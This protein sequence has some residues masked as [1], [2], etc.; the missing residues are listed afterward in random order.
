MTVTISALSGSNRTF[1]FTKT[2]PSQKLIDTADKASRYLFANGYGV[3]DKTFEQL[4]NAERLAI[5]DRYIVDGLRAVAQA[6]H[7]NSAVATARTQAENTADFE[8]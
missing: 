7:I 1:T 8:L 2:T 3:L 6:Y 5:L 4:T